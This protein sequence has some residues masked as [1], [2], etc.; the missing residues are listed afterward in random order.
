MITKHWLL[1]P[2]I[3]VTWTTGRRVTS[4][5]R[6]L[7][8]RVRLSLVYTLAYLWPSTK[9]NL[10][11]FIWK[12][13][14]I[15]RPGDSLLTVL[16]IDELSSRPSSSGDREDSRIQTGLRDRVALMI[17]ESTG[18]RLGWLCEVEQL[19]SVCLSQKQ[20][21]SNENHKHRSLLPEPLLRETFHL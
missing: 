13:R 16:V 18:S 14:D 1:L 4:T 21:Y 8:R 17:E 9:L 20:S 6:A 19:A 2:G 15:K 7:Y 12:H 10:W 3:G 11:C 5:I